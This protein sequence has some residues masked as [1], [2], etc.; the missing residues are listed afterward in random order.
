MRDGGWEVCFEKRGYRREG[1]WRVGGL[2]EWGSKQL[3]GWRLRW[4]TACG[5]SDE[6]VATRA[7]T[8]YRLA[9]HPTDRTSSRRFA[10]QLLTAARVENLLIRKTN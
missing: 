5:D 6:S 10:M 9:P 3:A 2:K 1:W 4:R 8:N 7:N